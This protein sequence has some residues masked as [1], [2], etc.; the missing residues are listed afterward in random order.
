MVRNSVDSNPSLDLYTGMSSSLEN[1]SPVDIARWFRLQA[2]KYSRRADEIERE[3]CL[4]TR[5]NPAPIAAAS[6]DVSAMQVK[7]EAIRRYLS[8]EGRARRIAQ[9][10]AGTGI[11]PGEVREIVGDHELGFVVRDRGWVALPNGE[12]ET[13]TP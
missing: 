9:I 1:L 6:S 11:Q 12:T 8:N 3:Y 13:A 4:N 5:Q 10:S 2:D 7:H